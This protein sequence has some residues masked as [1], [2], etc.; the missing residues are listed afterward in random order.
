MDAVAHPP[1]LSEWVY[2]IR[3]ICQTFAC[4]TFLGDRYELQEGLE[5]L[6]QTLP[7][8]DPRYPQQAAVVRE[9]LMIS[10]H[11]AAATLHGRYHR[12]VSARCAGTS[13]EEPAMA[14]WSTSC[15]DPRVPLALWTRGYFAAFDATHPWP[16][17]G[18]AA[19]IIRRQ[20]SD[21]PGLDELARHVNA[22]RRTLS[23]DSNGYTRC[24][25]VSTS[26]ESDCAGSSKR[27]AKMLR[28]RLGAPRRSATRAITIYPMRC[29]PGPVSSPATSAG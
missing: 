1:T 8:A 24:R 12:L 17:A 29:E 14:L 5:W 23:R 11:R 21:P 6:R 4:R 16:A 15:D 7:G 9:L 13:Y 19:A 28:A 26:F 27:C 3:S 2:R 10:V 18:R 22:S 20:Y 25:R